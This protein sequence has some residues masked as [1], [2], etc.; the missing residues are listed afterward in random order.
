MGRTKNKQ[1]LAV[2]AV[3]V[4]ILGTLGLTV[5]AQ[6]T[7]AAKNRRLDYNWDVRPILSDNCYRCH[8]PDAKSRQAGLRLDQKD[9]AYAQAIDPGKPDQSELMKRITSKD[10]TYRMPPPT[11]SAKP[12]TAA[13]VAT[14]REWILEGA[15]FKPHW[16]FVAP[17]KVEPPAV[18]AGSSVVNVIDRFILARLEKEGLKPS[19]EANKET[20]INRV[21]LTLTGL[22]PTLNQVDAFLADKSPNA[23]EKLVDRLLTSPAYGEHMA[24]S[25]MNIARYSESDGFLD[26]HHDRTFWPYRDWVI[27]AFNKNMPFDQFSTMQIAGD[28]MPNA[29]K[30]QKLPTAFLRVGKR[31]S[32]NGAIDEEYRVEY[33][34]DRANVIG[35]GFLALTTGCARCHDH[36]YDPIA[37]KE[38][39]SLTGF[40][41]STDEPGF[42]A[43]GYTTATGG[44]TIQW[45][46]PETDAKIVAAN[47][48]VKSAE[49]AEATARK[50]AFVRIAAN[51]KTLMSGNADE[52]AATVQHSLDAA[53]VAYYPFET[54][55][56]VPDT[57]ASVSRTAVDPPDGL[58]TLN[59][60]RK[61]AAF[62]ASFGLS[63]GS[64]AAP[65]TPAPP[66]AAMPRRMPNSMIREKLVMSPA[67]MR[68]V[69]PAILEEGGVRSGG[70][71]GNA[72]FFTDTNR[73][74]LGKDVGY[75][76]RTQP[77]SLDL[78]I[79][80]AKE[81][82]NSQVINHR[83]DDNSG[84]AGYKLNLEKNHLSF[85]MMHSWPYNMLHIVSMQPLPV[86]EWTEVSITYDGS[87]RASGIH[88]YINGAPA[89]VDVDR[90]NLTESILPR[91]IGAVFNEFVGLEFGRRFREVT[92]KDGG[93]DEIRI[94]NKALTPLE[95]GYLH[96]GPKAMETDRATLARELND[97]M[98]ANDPKVVEA[99][100]A[101]HEAREA[102]N[103][104]VSW[105]TE[106]MVMGDTPKP[107]QTYVLSRGLYNVRLDPVDPS[108]LNQI[109]P[110]AP[111]LPRNR[112]GLAKWLFDPKNPLTA[113]VFVN[114]MWQMQFGT[115]IV[116]T[117]E[118]F[119]M[120][121]SQPS[122]PQLLD[123]LAVDFMQSGWDI[124]RLNKMIVMSAAFRQ[125]SEAT[126]EM[127]KRDPKNLLIARGPR[128]RMSA[129]QIRDNALAVSG[130]LVKTIGGPSAYP[131]QPDGIWAAGTTLYRYPKPEDIPADEQHRRSLYTFVKR[132]TPP[133]SMSV[134]D[135]SERHA[136]IA[137]RLTSNTPLQALVLMDDPQ[138]MEAYRVL[139]TRVLKEKSDRDQQIQLVFR[140]ATRRMPKDSELAALRPYYDSQIAEFG[141]NK[142]KAEDLV[143][144]G[145]QPVDSSV[146]VGQM[147]ALTNVTAAVMNSPDA[148]SI[149]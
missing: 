5:Y 134:F 28:L 71:K 27:A 103:Q 146:D 142:K 50:N 149:H 23:Y 19:R 90:D 118:D 77:F 74:F 34:L 141:A 127:E 128:R 109:F 140:L 72:L 148:Y 88:L 8:G 45:T 35:T 11:A 82:E 98:M 52:L 121:G 89:E 124:Q 111:K 129:E 31:T 94:F 51:L 92:L 70:A 144:V 57:L 101:L 135:F 125:A 12:L 132:N 25:W 116:E 139:A 49:A 29:T 22:P 108:G 78:S 56:P 67:G 14:L 106:I 76:E 65:T 55:E 102:Q 40:F 13:E 43:P 93:I 2:C 130:L 87:S 24:A 17:I 46:T 26:D 137:R 123:W 81:Y 58:V 9:S 42:F 7:G 122:H 99:G 104:I 75:Y 145:V 143:H 6:E 66:P 44:P 21:A 100:N 80:A 4:G 105:Q 33:A 120:Q 69:P 61:A 53:T 30:E 18:P 68:G 83:D 48:K 62:A 60:K 114:R 97:L 113:R 107:R 63:E 110:F 112:I 37:Q 85:F 3:S 1:V 39:Y 79:Y 95:V 73:G 59:K 32:E 41:N 16:A 133:P 96:S 15:E 131:Y 36:K 47:A 138:Y 64:A 86:K 38:Y 119:G 117:S 54:T 84:G 91:L 20:L 147:A 126:D 115:G 10:P 136:S